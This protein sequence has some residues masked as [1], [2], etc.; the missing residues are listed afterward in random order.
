LDRQE[1]VFDSVTTTL[2]VKYTDLKDSYKYVGY[3]SF[4]AFGAEGEQ[5]VDH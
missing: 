4:G 5:E 2:V 1:R 3:Q